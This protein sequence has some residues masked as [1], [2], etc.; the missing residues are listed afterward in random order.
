MRRLNPDL[1]WFFYDP[2][3]G[4][5]AAGTQQFAESFLAYMGRDRT[6]TMLR[7]GEDTPTPDAVILFPSHS[8]VYVPASFFADPDDPSAEFDGFRQTSAGSAFSNWSFE[9]DSEAFATES[10]LAPDERED[11]AALAANIGRIFQITD[12]ALMA[13]RGLALSGIAIEVYWHLL[14]VLAEPLWP[15]G[16]G[17]GTR[18]AVLDT[19]IDPNNAL[20]T[21]GSLGGISFVPG[22]A[23]YNDD[24]GHGTHVTGILAARPG[25]AS[26]GRPLYWSIAPGAGHYSVKVLDRAGNG[27][28]NQIIQGL[29]WARNTGVDIISMSLGGAQ[30]PPAPVASAVALASQGAVIIAAA[31]NNGPGNDTV[32]WP[33][34]YREV[35]GVGAVDRNRAIADFSSRGPADPNAYV[36]DNVECVAPG[37]DIYSNRLGGGAQDLVTKSGTSMATPIVSGIC[38]LLKQKDRSLVGTNGFRYRLRRS[39]IDLGIGGP[40]NWYGLGLVH[41]DPSS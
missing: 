13:A 40:D 1:G 28:W 31:G 12:Q 25:T 20:L 23:S 17:E 39:Y 37:V 9:R 35:I 29:D 4:A 10:V 26:S 34:R 6:A 41:F 19:G 30:Q 27:P 2:T 38:A 11:L 14:Q 7:S 3:A 8:A 15:F 22:T 32:T 24:N 18:I 36:E 5:T 16:L 33:A 21:S